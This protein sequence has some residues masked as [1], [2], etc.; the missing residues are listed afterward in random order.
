LAGAGEQFRSSRSGGSVG[1]VEYGATEQCSATGHDAAAGNATSGDSPARHAA[2]GDAAAR[3]AARHAVANT[4]ASASTDDAGDA[5]GDA[6]AHSAAHL[7]TWAGAA[8]SDSNASHSHARGRNGLVR[9]SRA[10]AGPGSSPLAGAAR[11]DAVRRDDGRHDTCRGWTAGWRDDD[12]G[13][14]RRGPAG[15]PQGQR[16]ARLGRGEGVAVRHGVGLGKL[17][18][19]PPASAS[20]LRGEALPRVQR[21][22]WV[23]GG[24]QQR[25]VLSQLLLL[26]LRGQGF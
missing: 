6:A 24:G 20:A 5:A 14:G 8:Q 4:P 18:P 10:R 1:S 7:L 16:N 3:H 26:R 9:A 17:Q 22:G 25:G 19:G 15:L 23:G 13:R 12:A 2:A 11:Y 21:A